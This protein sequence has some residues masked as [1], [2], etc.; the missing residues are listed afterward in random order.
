MLRVL[1]AHSAALRTVELELLAVSLASFG[2]P[3]ATRTADPAGAAPKI[4]ELERV[5]RTIGAGV[6]QARHENGVYLCSLTSSS[7]SMKY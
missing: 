1:S 6:C 4:S 5:S 2:A 3:K 7:S